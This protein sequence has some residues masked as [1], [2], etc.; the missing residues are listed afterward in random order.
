MDKNRDK[1]SNCDSHGT[2][3]DIRCFLYTVLESTWC[4]AICFSRGL[5]GQTFLLFDTFF[6]TVC[7]QLCGCVS[8]VLEF[9]IILATNKLADNKK[10]EILYITEWLKGGFF[11]KTMRQRLDFWWHKMRRKQSLSNKIRCRPIFLAESWWVFCLI[12]IVCKSF[13]TN[14]SSESSSFMIDELIC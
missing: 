3:V 10:L 13:F 6:I 11:M 2:C 7:Y 5:I 1:S 4:C 9:R 12:D 8:W 14:H